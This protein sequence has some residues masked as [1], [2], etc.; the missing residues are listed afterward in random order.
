MIVAPRA[1]VREPDGSGRL[2]TMKTVPMSIDELHQSLAAATNYVNAARLILMA[3]NESTA[4]LALANLE[5]AEGQLLRA[6]EFARPLG[7]GEI[8]RELNTA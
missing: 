7:E 4:E 5:R 2:Q 6:G 3:V 1:W 8:T